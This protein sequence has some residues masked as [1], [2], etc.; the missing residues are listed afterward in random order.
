[1]DAQNNGFITEIKKLNDFKVIYDDL[2]NQF[3]LIRDQNDKCQADN[4]NLS[5]QLSSLNI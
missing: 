3:R 2:N 4:K 5:N 1:M